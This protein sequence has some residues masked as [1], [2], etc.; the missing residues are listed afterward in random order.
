MA[1]T[2]SP[3]P[4]SAA[5]PPATVTSK[6]VRLCSTCGA[7][8]RGQV[9]RALDGHHH[10]NCFRCL[11]CNVE[12][13]HKFFPSKGPDGTPR[14]LCET[15]YFRRLDLLCAKCGQAL[16]GPFISAFGRKWHESHF[17]CSLCPKVFSKDDAIYERNGNI[18]C[19][20]HYSLL[21]AAKCGSCHTAVLRRFIEVNRNEGAVEHW[22]LNCYTIYQSWSARLVPKGIP[23]SESEQPASEDLLA[24]QQKA[25][26]HRTSRIISVLASFEES[27]ADCISQTLQLAA[28]NNPN[29]CLSQAARFLNHV[30]ALFSGIDA[31]DAKLA[32]FGDRKVLQTNKEPKDLAKQVVALFTH[33]SSPAAETSQASRAVVTELARLLK[34]II[35]AGL[36]GAIKLDRLASTSTG[37]DHFL[38][39]LETATAPSLPSRPSSPSDPS[40]VRLPASFPVSDLKTESCAVCQLPVE[41]DC[42]K[43]GPLRWHGRCFSCASCGDSQT[44]TY[45]TAYLESSTRRVYCENCSRGRVGVTLG[46][47]AVSQLNQYVFLLRLGLTRLCSMLNERAASESGGRLTPTSLSPADAAV[48][49]GSRRSRSVSGVDTMS[50]V[51]P[52]PL[53]RS[54]R[55]TGST[56]LAAPGSR[57]RSPGL[58]VER[59]R[60]SSTAL[61]AQ[62]DSMTLTVE[63]ADPG[64]QE[65]SDDEGPAADANR[66]GLASSDSFPSPAV[67]P[68]PY[69]KPMIQV[70]GGQRF[71]SELSPLDVVSLKSAIVPALHRYLESFISLE[72]LLDI[73]ESKRNTIWDKIVSSF[74]AADRKGKSKG[75]FGVPLQELINAHG[76]QSDLNPGPGSVHIPLFLDTC[77]RV[78]RTQDLRVEGIFRKNGNI[79]RLKAVADDLDKDGDNMGPLLRENVIQ[80]SAL[81][82]RFL[83]D[84]PDPLL[85]FDLFKVFVSTQKLPDEPSRKKALHYAFC[86]LPKGNREVLEVVLLFL[87]F[88]A[89]HADGGGGTGNKMDIDN[90]ATVVAPCILYARPKEAGKGK[91]AAS[92]AEDTF[93]AISVVR[94]LM[95][96][97]DE[98]VLV[99]REFEKKLDSNS[100]EVIGGDAGGDAVMGNSDVWQ[101]MALN[102][103]RAAG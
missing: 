8:L 58:D 46:F 96:H 101:R 95:D 85:T 62:F 78:M 41:E 38:D 48:A 81:L 19:Q 26:E 70:L 53:A 100:T 98:F 93:M 91:D 57:T 4:R 3:E 29:E 17:Q 44:S 89:E 22:H 14:P 50:E 55:P 71:L 103:E 92:V 64:D 76:V 21:F 90:L 72:Q 27:A 75:T 18:Y 28:N 13:A 15:D 23:I 1:T 9:V 56:S 31:I 20:F 82:R 51:E 16:R 45:R 97:L 35:T 79:K 7:P 34:Y 74:K 88:V 84:M 10:V 12:V 33:L 65:L 94:T 102:V 59:G 30:D 39:V 66:A 24:E 69:S 61:V 87:R 2:P 80:L 99:P 63:G 5:G 37:L 73:V 36:R 40:R 25:M 67:V 83:R 60:A 86:L 32:A 47:E 68:P 52:E 42:I 43:L 49:K 11:D 54:H 77:L 6:E